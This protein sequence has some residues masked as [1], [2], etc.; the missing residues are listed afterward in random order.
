MVG[1]A[2]QWTELRLTTDRAEVDGRRSRP[3]ASYFSRV[4]PLWFAL[5]RYT[6][7]VQRPTAPV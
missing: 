6:L 5:P 7:R 2:R 1:S 3:A 4:T